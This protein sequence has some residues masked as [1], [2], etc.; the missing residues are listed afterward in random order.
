[1]GNISKD[2]I[3]TELIKFVRENI[4]DNQIKLDPETPFSEIGIDSMSIIQ[5]VLFIERK[6]KVALSEKELTPDNLRSIRSLT[7]CTFKY[8]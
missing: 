3:S 4:L 7:E 1:M 8:L 6:F 2:N 5:I